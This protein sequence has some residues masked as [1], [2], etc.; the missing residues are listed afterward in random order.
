ML[1]C[2]APNLNLTP[3][4]YLRRGGLRG[5]GFVLARLEVASGDLLLMQHG[6]G[7]SPH[8]NPLPIRERRKVLSP[9]GERV[10]VRG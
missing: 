5:R 2:G 3:Y 6:N 1:V 7:N 10:R 8:L 9:L 4:P